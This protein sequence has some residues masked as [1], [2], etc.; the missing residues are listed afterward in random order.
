MDKEP[1]DLSKADF[2]PQNLLLMAHAIAAFQ[3]AAEH[4]HDVADTV[5]MG[6]DPSRFDH[7]EGLLQEHQAQ[8]GVASTIDIEAALEEDD[9]KVALYAAAMLP[10]TVAHITAPF[11][12]KTFYNKDADMPPKILGAHAKNAFWMVKVATELCKVEDDE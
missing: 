11:V 10:D 7:M 3:K 5:L 4:L 1:L 2:S 9:A 6:K 8:A 12:Q